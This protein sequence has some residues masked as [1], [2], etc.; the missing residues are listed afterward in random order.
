LRSWR[1]NGQEAA[2]T[3]RSEASETCGES[4]GR[5]GMKGRSSEKCQGW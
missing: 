5:E 3:K 4:T 2:E 1:W